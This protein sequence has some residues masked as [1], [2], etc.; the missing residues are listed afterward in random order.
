MPENP[1][2]I[3]ITCSNV[4]DTREKIK[5][6][7]FVSTENNTYVQFMYIEEKD[8]IIPIIRGKL[9]SFTRSMYKFNYRGNM[10][11]SRLSENEFRPD[12]I[13]N[14]FESIF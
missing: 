14:Q 9:N 13:A 11:N 7:R 8:K 5:D 2:E 12:Y 4:Q 6:Y 1:K 3:K 10:F